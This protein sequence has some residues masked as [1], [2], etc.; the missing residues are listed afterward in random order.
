[1]YVEGTWAT[2]PIQAGSKFKWDM[3][4]FP[5]GPKAHVMASAG[6]GYGITR[7][8][9][10]ADAA[11]IYLNEYLSTAGQAYMWGIT[12]RGS[13]ARLSAWPSYLEL[14]SSHPPGP[15]TPRKNWRAWPSM[16]FWINLQLPK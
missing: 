7:D 6:S 15:R 5:K 2:P 3:A 8:S 16:T 11:W 4:K 10:A 13:P 14:A 9:K 1:M 12:G